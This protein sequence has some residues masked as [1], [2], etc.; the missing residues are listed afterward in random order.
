MDHRTLKGMGRRDVSR[1][2]SA[3]RCCWHEKEKKEKKNSV[4]PSLTSFFYVVCC[5]LQDKRWSAT[6]KTYPSWWA[7]EW[8]WPEANQFTR[9]STRY[10]TTL[11]NTDDTGKRRRGRK[12]KH[13]ENSIKTT[14]SPFRF[15]VDIGMAVLVLL[16]TL[17]MA[18]G[19]MCGCCGKRP[20]DRYDDDFGTRAT[21]ASCLMA[22]VNRLFIE[23]ERERGKSFRSE[24]EKDKS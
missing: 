19:L 11:T 23:K 10:K 22:Y 16:I 8:R 20:A 15:Y 17:C 6:R 9:T 12:K 4:D 2:S 5:H 7:V 3:L 18:F 1:W 14:H 21:G 24:R 13:S